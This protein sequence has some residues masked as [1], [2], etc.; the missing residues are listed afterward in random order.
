MNELCGLQM[1]ET[2]NEFVD[3]GTGAYFV[4]CIEGSMD[5]RNGTNI[6]LCGQCGYYL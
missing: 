4:S 3:V 5:L 6:C 2:F 1:Y